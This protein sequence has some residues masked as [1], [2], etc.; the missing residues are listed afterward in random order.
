MGMIEGTSKR[1]H[2]AGTAAGEQPPQLPGRWHDLT[3]GHVIS[4]HCD[5]GQRYAE[6]RSTAFSILCGDVILFSIR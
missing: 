1:E 5:K 6:R 2:G 3:T 4:Y